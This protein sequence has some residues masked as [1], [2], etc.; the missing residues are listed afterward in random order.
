MRSI[1]LT[2]AIQRYK[3]T[4]RKTVNTIANLYFY[5]AQ[6]RVI[7]WTLCHTIH[8]LH[9]EMSLKIL[10]RCY[11][12]LSKYYVLIRIKTKNKSFKYQSIR[13]QSIG[14]VT[15]RNSPSGRATMS[16]TFLRPA[17]RNL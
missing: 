1:P 6:N 2:Y 17:S 11:A 5:L 15:N 16:R 8:T 7:Q 3:I 10:D 13:H 9:H 14:I 12:K 4:L